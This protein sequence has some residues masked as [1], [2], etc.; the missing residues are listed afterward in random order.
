MSHPLVSII[1]TYYNHQAFIRETVRSALDQTHRHLEVIVVDDG[2][3][4]PAAPYLANLEEVQ[5]FRIENSGV[6]TA[7]NFGF[8]QSKGE[9]LVF[10]DGDDR[11]LPGALDAQLR[12]L[13]TC[14]KAGLAFG[15]VRR[16]DEH[17]Q[18]TRPLH[19]CKP[20]AN[21]FLMLLESNPIECPGAA[22]IARWAF[23]EAQQFDESDAIVHGAEDYDLY[24]RITRSTPAVRHTGGVAEYREHSF[25]MSHNKT[26]MSHSVTYVLNKVEPK[27]RTHTELRRLQYG[28]SRWD[29]ALHP[30][31]TLGYKL[32]RSY[33]GLRALLGISFSLALSEQLPGAIRTARTATPSRSEAS[34]K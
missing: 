5:C 30:K 6:C 27:L 24:L 16:I 31:P 4:T 18:V 17:G 1:I 13:E 11:L 33:H 26:R 14:P 29:H 9:Y 3:K 15:A 10:L 22:L 28:R 34:P 23:M 25:N 7:R 8:R 19:I 20:R 21:Y 32:R 2:S 12:A